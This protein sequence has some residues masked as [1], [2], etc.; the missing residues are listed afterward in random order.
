MK[1]PRQYSFIL[2]TYI[3][4]IIS[5]LLFY[6]YKLS[7]SN[8]YNQIPVII[9][10][11][12]PE[13]YN[14]DFYIQEMTQ[15]TPRFYYYHLIY[16]GVKLG[17]SL[18]WVCF[19]L[20][21]I[22]FSS[23]LLGLYFLGR[24]FGQSR[25]L[26]TVFTFLGLAATINGRIGHA[27]LFR[28]DP[29]PATL[30]MGLVIWGFY[31]CFSKKWILGYLFFGLTCFLQFLVGALPGLLMAIPL[32]VS[33]IKNRNFKQIF[34]S[35]FALGICVCLIYIPMLLA[36]NTNSGAISNEEF[37]YLY[38]Y[39]RHPHHLIFSGFGL[40]TSRGWLNFILFTLGG[41]FCINSSKSLDKDFKFQ[42][43]IVVVLSCCLLLV[44]YVFVEIYPINF[45]AKL[46]FARTTPFAQLMILIGISVLVNEEYK[47]GHLP[48]VFLLMIAPILKGAGILLFIL[49]SSLWLA[50]REPKLKQY[51]S[52]IVILGWGLI[53]VS[54]LAISSQRYVLVGLFILS[55]LILAYYLC[56]RYLQNIASEK[57][58]KLLSIASLLFLFPFQFFPDGIILDLFFLLWLGSVSNQAIAKRLRAISIFLFIVFMILY[59]HYDLFLL[60]AI[61]FPL[62]LDSLIS[63]TERKRIITFGLAILLSLYFSLN[64]LGMLPG[65][66]SGFF[67]SR[68]KINAASD[69]DVAILARNFRQLSPD[70]ALVLVPPLDEQFRFYSQRS[71]VFSFKSFPFTDAGIK[72]WRDRLETIAGTKDF[73]KYALESSLNNFYAKHSNS[74][75]IAIAQQFEADYI[76]TR[77][78]WHE[79][80]DGLV[81]EQQGDWVIYQIFSE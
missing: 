23:F 44:N 47:A 28:I 24:I 33:A 46:Q 79:D 25:L 71:I 50:H 11:L 27:D 49:G 35:F 42:L 64:L 17:I 59:R 72:V 41:L 22:A 63:Q 36:G 31:F 61:A 62:L 1:Q 16:W 75:L 12:N 26:A 78:D 70:N 65:N 51:P 73:R 38:G 8:I 39:L 67:Q 29:I 20:Y 6:G 18:P 52:D 45:I 55:F 5:S 9:S 69:R 81:I 14:E 4:V 43:S 58:V 21:F 13:F 10:L 30:A 7:S 77:L 19:I 32:L 60:G 53:A 34:F 68:I 76:L 74:T 40:G 2:A 37:S 66:L 48:I 57:I 56:P 3:T 80:L 15:F 54:F